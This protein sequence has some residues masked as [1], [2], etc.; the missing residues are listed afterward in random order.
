MNDATGLLASM[1][2]ERTVDFADW[3]G[4]PYEVRQEARDRALQQFLFERVE[5]NLASELIE[6]DAGLGL[7]DTMPCCSPLDLQA[8]M[9]SLTGMVALLLLGLVTASLMLECPFLLRRRPFIVEDACVQK[10]GWVTWVAV[11]IACPC[12]ALL[13][14]S[15]ADSI[16]QPVGL[17]CRL[18]EPMLTQTQTNLLGSAA[19][20]ILLTTLRVAVQGRWDPH[21]C[22]RALVYFFGMAYVVAIIAT[23]ALRH[24]AMTQLMVDVSELA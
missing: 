6:A 18:V 15:V 2:Q 23:A 4:T 17:Q 9:C 12:V 11:A 21:R 14:F 3:E 24:S 1:D 16:A 20:A 19:G 22:Y 7:R 5:P 13:F 10:L 8:M